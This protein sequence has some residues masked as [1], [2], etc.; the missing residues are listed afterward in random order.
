M[1]QTIWKAMVQ[2]VLKA[3]SLT[4]ATDYEP[5]TMCI[6]PRPHWSFEGLKAALASGTKLVA[7][8]RNEAKNKIQPDPSI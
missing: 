6:G 8:E 5:M 4:Y 7:V 2:T 3:M 1:T